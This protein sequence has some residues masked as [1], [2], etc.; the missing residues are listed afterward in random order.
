MKHTKFDARNF[1]KKQKRLCKR[2]R[3]QLNKN[4]IDYHKECKYTSTINAMIDL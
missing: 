4:E 3:L 1:K 2:C